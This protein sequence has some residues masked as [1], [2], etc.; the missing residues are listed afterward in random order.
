MPLPS[1]QRLY[2]ALAD[3]RVRIQDFTGASK[4][5]HF[6]NIRNQSGYL[7]PLSAAKA[8]YERDELV[9]CAN[10]LALALVSGGFGIL[11]GEDERITILTKALLEEPECGWH[12]W[13]GEMYPGMASLVAALNDAEGE[14]MPST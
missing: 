10:C 8:W 3:V 2:A 11:K 4:L 14:S 5:S 9:W 1:I 7:L 13:T 12:N 6:F